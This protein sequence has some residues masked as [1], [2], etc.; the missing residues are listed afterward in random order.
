VLGSSFFIPVFLLLGVFYGVD[1]GQ[2]PQMEGSM[3][4]LGICDSQDAG[5]CL[6]V[7]GSLVSAVN[8]E[9]L[10]RKKLWGGFPRLSILEVLRLGGV[11][12]EDVD[13]VVIG[14]SITP[15]LIFRAFRGIH[16]GVRR[17]SGQFG[18]LLNLFITYQ[19]I[20]R[21]SSLI[22]GL[23][24]LAGRKVIAREL[25]KLRIQ[26]KVISI[27]H[28]SAHAYGAFATSPFDSALV[29]TADGLG[30]GLG[31]TVSVGER[32]KGLLCIHEES[33]FSALTLYYSRL[34]EALG[35]TPIKDEGKVNALAG[36]TLRMPLLGDAKRLLRHKEGRFN[37]QNHLLPCSRQGWPYGLFS[38]YSREEVAS[39]FQTHLENEMKD[40]VRHYVKKTGQKNVCLAGGLFA[41]VK[42]N[43]RLAMMDEVEGVWVFPHMGDGGLAVGGC[44]AYLGSEPSPLPHVYLGSSFTDTKAE[45]ALRK[46]GLSYRKPE[47]PDL[48]VAR[49]LSLGK[50]VAVCRGRMEWGPRALGNRSILLHGQDPDTVSWL[51]K[52]LRRSHFMPFAPAVLLEDG[53]RCFIGLEK[54]LH[55]SRFMTISFDAT[56]YFRKTYKGAIHKDGTARP[57]LVDDQTN[58][59]FASIL[60]EYKRRT[61]LCC[62]INTSFNM[63]EEPIVCSPEDA[64]QA[65]LQAGLDAL[66]LG[67]YLVENR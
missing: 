38:K 53:P 1:R 57:Q 67:S 7:H 42:L 11:K 51:N 36:Y 33:G 12:P 52:K 18:Y 56:E 41:N 2:K 50:I 55:S 45:E 10:C 23:E 21:K 20:A 14:T 39:S 8:E 17:K 25:R 58:P 66:L 9:R 26:S 49:L 31:L 65:F 13:V 64:V 60:R 15:N 44:L 61:G 16:Q 30:D 35:F 27:D 19:T 43:Q 48:E 29:V 22:L 59:N 24:A 4:V 28:H 3:I 62:L 37:L 54:A 34:T 47:N 40:F 63:H 6:F 32:G 5:A 46:A